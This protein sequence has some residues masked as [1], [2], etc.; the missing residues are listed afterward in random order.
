MAVEFLWGLKPGVS[1]FTDPLHLTDR[2]HTGNRAGRRG[3]R[4]HLGGGGEVHVLV[5]LFT[6]VEGIVGCILGQHHRHGFSFPGLLNFVFLYYF[7]T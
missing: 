7:C 6:V 5:A 4:L 2:V 3:Q 1:G